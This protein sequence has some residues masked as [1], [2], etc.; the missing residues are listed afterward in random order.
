MSDSQYLP[1]R[2]TVDNADAVFAQLQQQ[3]DT[4][5]ALTTLDLSAVSHCDSAGIAM[6]IALKSQQQG[7]GKTLGYTHPNPQ[8]SDLARFLKVDTLLFADNN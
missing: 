1:E 6:L 3:I 8:L 2:L 5:A 7:R 4:A